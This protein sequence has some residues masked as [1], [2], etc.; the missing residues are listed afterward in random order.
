[1]VPQPGPSSSP[2]ARRLVARLPCLGIFLLLL[3][4]G[5]G[6]ANHYY[7][8][9]KAKERDQET[10]NP[11]DYDLA[12]THDTKAIRLDPKNFFAYDR[13][14]FFYNK[15]GEYD[16]AIADLNEAIRLKPDYAV[17]YNNRG[18]SYDHKGDYDKAIADYNEA[19]R[20]KPDYAEAYNNRGFSYNHKGEYEKAI[21]DYNEAVRLKPDYAYAYNTRGLAYD[22]K[23][24]HDKAIA[25]FSEAIRL[26]PNFAVAYYNRG[27]AHKRRGD[28][29]K[30]CT[31][32]SSA[33]QLKP[34]FVEANG[35]LAWLLAV[36]PD[37][38]VRNGAKALEY[39]KKA[40]EL[41]EW[42]NSTIFEILA[43]AYAEIGDFD[44]AVKWENKSLASNASDAILERR[45]QRLSLYEQKKPYHEEKP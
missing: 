36:C 12:I 39:A 33:I 43:A 8:S 18:F 19:V 41:S 1:M 30:A 9:E 44:S 15:K 27:F 26:K 11:Y 40:C 14:G 23:G 38:N 32:Y 24:D 16:K 6:C 21:T 2:P 45:G 28:Y 34:D 13:R 3:L 7:Q 37:P 31:D 29:D 42:K 10:D 22:D 25:D 5:Q 4:A 17:A 20:L 35:G